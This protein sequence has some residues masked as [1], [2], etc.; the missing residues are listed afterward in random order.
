[1]VCRQVQSSQIWQ[2]KYFFRY[3]LQ[4]I[5]GQAQGSQVSS[6]WFKCIFWYALETYKFQ[7]SVFETKGFKKCMGPKYSRFF[8][9]TFNWLN[10]MT[11]ADK[12][13]VF[14]NT[15]GPRMVKLVK[16]TSKVVMLLSS[17]CSRMPFKSCFSP[18]LHRKWL[19]LGQL[20]PS[21]ISRQLSWLWPVSKIITIIIND[22]NEGI[23][24]IVVSTREK[25]III[26]DEKIYDIFFVC[27]DL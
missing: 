26:S 23:I 17:I 25:K 6:Q 12:D 27:R 7:I 5:I 15:S 3:H 2:I 18:I 20:H 10:D 14:L 11:S 1:M 16:V 24:L 22:A 4:Q 21:L 9:L 8:T 19:G 13:C